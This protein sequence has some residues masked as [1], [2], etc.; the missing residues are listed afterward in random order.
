MVFC[1]CMNDDETCERVAPPKGWEFQSCSDATITLTRVSEIDWNVKLDA[2]HPSIYDAYIMGA[3]KDD[4]WDI[5]IDEPSEKRDEM[6]KMNVKR[7]SGRDRSTKEDAVKEIVCL[8]RYY[9][10]WKENYDQGV[11]SKYKELDREALDNLV[12]CRKSFGI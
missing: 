12:G 8:A 4:K 5:H 1:S 10:T 11:T 9:D 2:R 3:W 7:S 6:L